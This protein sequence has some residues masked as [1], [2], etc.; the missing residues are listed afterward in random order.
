MACLQSL[1]YLLQCDGTLE[2]DVVSSLL[3]L[4][5]EYLQMYLRH[6]SSTDLCH[7]EDHVTLVWAVAFYI[8]EHHHQHVE[9]V[10]IFLCRWGRGLVSHIP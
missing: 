2:R 4:T 3:P 5:T 10:N 8:I 6:A 1:L 9:Q 7:S